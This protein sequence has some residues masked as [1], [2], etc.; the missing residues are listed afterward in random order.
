MQFTAVSVALYN[1]DMMLKG[2]S[3]LSGNTA[4]GITEN[5]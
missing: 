3:T 1:T 2:G 5:S 4:V